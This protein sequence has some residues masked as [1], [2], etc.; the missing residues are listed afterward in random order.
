MLVE[1]S[2]GAS[3]SSVG[4]NSAADCISPASGVPVPSYGF[5]QGSSKWIRSSAARWPRAWETKPLFGSIVDWPPTGPSAVAAARPPRGPSGLASNT[6]T[7]YGRLASTTIPTMAINDQ[8]SG[9]IVLSTFGTRTARDHCAIA[10]AGG[11]APERRGRRRES[12]RGEFADEFPPDNRP[13]HRY[14]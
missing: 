10:R 1:L 14:T 11:R 4:G 3:N 2:V 13:D 12:R 8:P 5:H 7:R 9:E 6:P